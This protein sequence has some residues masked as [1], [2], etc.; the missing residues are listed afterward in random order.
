[1]F[2]DLR[3]SNSIVGQLP[4]Y[5]PSEYPNFVNFLKDYYRFLETNSNP[6]DLLNGIQ[7][8][9]DVD[10]YTGISTSANLKTPIPI[11]A[12]QIIVLG[13]VNFP[14][15]NGLLKINDEVILYKTR[16]HIQ[17]QYQS[18]K[19]TVFDG[20]VR[21]YD[22]NDLDI[23]T[24]FTANIKTEPSRH[25]ATSIVYNQSY[26]YIL[27][28]LEKL[29]S[30]YLIDFPKNVLEDNLD[31]LNIDTVLKKVKDF[32][33]SKGTPQ[34]I[35]F[36][37]KFL[38]Q[39]T[40][41]LRNYKENLIAPSEATYQS[42][43]VV[44]AESLDNFYSPDLV[45]DF[46]VQGGV[47]YPIQTVENV[48]SFASQV[49]EF[50]VSNGQGLKP[51][52]FTKITT[53]PVEKNGRLLV[54]V[55]STYGFP[56]SG[57]IRIGDAT[58]KYTNKESN[59][60][61]LD[62]SETTVTYDLGDSVY[63]FDTLATIKS[64]PSSY[65][66]IYAGV[67]GFK[68]DKNYTY[69][70]KGDTGFV[71]NF[72]VEDSKLVT[73]WSY[74]DILPVT[75]NN[76]LVSGIT[77]LYTDEES[78]Y[79]Y[80][81]SIPFYEFTYD[82]SK[83]ILEDPAFIR[84]IPKNFTKTAEGFKDSTPPAAPV[85]FLRDG[86]AI[87]NWKSR[88]TIVRGS[89]SSIEIEN[90]GQLFN[91]HNPP[92]IIIDA[93]TKLPGQTVN[94]IRAQANLIIHGRIEQVYIKNT[95]SGYVGTPIITVIKDPTDTVY[96]GDN[97]RQAILQPIVVK[98]KI[99]KVR[100]VDPGLGYT[101]QPSYEITATGYTTPASLELFVAGPIGQVQ[102]TNSGSL[103][104]QNPSYI[105]TK[106]TGATGVV[107]VNNGKITEVQVVNGGQEY[108]SRPE[109]TVIDGAGKG[110]G[111]V[112][113]ANYDEIA[114]QVTGFT[115]INSG[116][117]YSDIGTYIV[118]R[119][120]GFNEILNINVSSWNLINNYDK[121]NVNP[122]YDI[123][124][125]AYFAGELVV[126]TSATIV[127]KFEELQDF[128]YYTRSVPYSYINA[129]GNL[130]ESRRLLFYENPY[131]PG[132]T[133][134][135]EDPN[136]G[137]IL[138]GLLLNG[139]DLVDEATINQPLP[140]DIS[141]GSS[142]TSPTEAN[143][144]TFV[145]VTSN[146]VITFRQTAGSIEN[147]WATEQLTP[148][149]P[150]PSIQIGR[151]DLIVD[152]IYFANITR[153][154]E[155]Y[156]FV[157]R[158]EGYHFDTNFSKENPVV[159]E[160]LIYAKSPNVAGDNPIKINII[161][162]FATSLDDAGIFIT[163]ADDN[164]YEFA[165]VEAQSG[166]S[167]YY[168]TDNIP[169]SEPKK[170]KYFSILGA[171]KKLRVVDNRVSES[172]G[173]NDPTS[174]SPIIGWALDGAPIYGPYGYDNPLDPGSDI[175]KMKSGWKKFTQ[176]QFNNAG[177]SFRTQDS[178]T[179]AGLNNY[180]IGSFVEDYYW[181]EFNA[182]L[183]EQNGRYCVTPD[184]PNG[185]YA[186]FMTVDSN[187]KENGFPYY[188]GSNFAGK[189][190]SEFN[191]LQEVDIESITGIR[192][193]LNA[194][195]NATPKFIDPGRFV[196]DSVP[197]SIDA[198]L[199]YIDVVSPGTNYKIGDTLVFN[200]DDTEGTGAAGFVSVIKGQSVS[201]VSYAEYDYL[202][203][204]DENIPF[205]KGSTI[206]S[207]YGF[208]A[209]IH[210]IDQVNKWMYLSNVTG[211]L[212]TK[213][214]PIFDTTLTLEQDYKTETIGA[215]ISD[216]ILSANETTAELVTD[217]DSVTSYFELDTFI[218]CT[219]SNFNS[220][221]GI[222]V[223]I[224]INQEYMKVIATSSNYVLVERGFNSSQDSHSAG[225]T[226]TLLYTLEV[227]DSSPF[228]RGDIIRLTTSGVSSTTENFKII[229]IDVSKQYE[230]VATKILNGTGT[231]SGSVYYFYLDGQLQQNSLATSPPPLE[232]QVVVLDNNG[233]IE[234]IVIGNYP[235]AI[236]NPIA[237][238]TNQST[239]NPDTI[240]PNTEII[241]TTYKHTLIVERGLFGSTP[242]AHYPRQSVNRLRFVNGFVSYY[243]EDRILARLNA[244]NNLLVL[245]D[246][247]A[248]T[249]STKGTNSYTVGLSNNTLT[250]ITGSLILYEG[251]TYIFEVDL[252]SD[253]IAV[254]FYTPG[255]K[256]REYFDITIQRTFDITGNLEEFAL[257]PKSSDLTRLVM[258][259]TSLDDNTF[260]DVSI[261][262][263][264]EPINGEYKVVNSTNSY[265]EFYTKKDPILSLTQQYTRNNIRYTTTSSNS[266]G[267][268]E[269]ITLSS[270]GYY[271]QTV[272]R[273]DGVSSAEGTGAVLEAVSESIGRIKS[274]RSINTGYGYNP[275]PT[276][277]PSLLFP[278][279][280]KIS[281][282]FIVAST[283][284][285]DS[286]SDY[287]FT[288][289][290]VVSGGGLADG[291]SNHAS[292]Q[293]T[294]NNGRLIS[295]DILFAG[296]QYVSAPIID[297][298]KY[299][300]VTI[301][302]AG[303]LSF[304]FNFKQFILDDDPFKV[305]AYYR[306]NGIL[307]YV[308]SSIT[309]YASIQAASVSC[310]SSP[311]GNV[312]NPLNFITIPN[313][314]AP[315]YYELICVSR[316]AQATVLMQKSP[317]IEGEKVIFNNNPNYFGFIS[318]RKGWQANNS[319]L[320]IENYNYN[321]KVDDTI[322]GV[323]SSAYGV[324]SDT[325][326][327]LTSAELSSL[328]ETPKQF[329]TSKSFLGFNSLK[330]Q[331]SFRYQKFAYEIGTDIPS[332]Q[333]RENYLNTA[334][335]AG[336]N[337]FART[338]ISSKSKVE[339]KASSVVK[340][341][342]DINN[343]VRL[344]QKYNYLVT[345]NNGFDEVLVLN[346]LLTDVKSIN[347]SVVAAFEDISD[348]F[349]GIETSFELKVVDPVTPTDINGN[350]N[351]IQDYEI[352]QM[353]VLLD[354]IIQTYGTSWTVTDSDKVF[355]FTSTQNA[356]QLM[357]QGEV[358]TYRQFN[359]DTVIYGYNVITS[360]DT[361]TFALLQ[362]DNSVFPA[363]IFSSIDQDNYMVFVDGA[364]QLN[365][366]FTISGS[367]N[368]EIIFSEVIP[369][370]SQVSV[371]Y[372]NNFIKNEFTNS[373]YTTGSPLVLSSKP[374]TTSKESYFVFIDGIL[375]S[376]DD[377]NLDG[378]N[379]IEF[380]Y[381]F[382]YDSLIVIID[383]LGV[384]LESSTHNII[385]QL[386][387]YKIEDGQ[388]EIPAGYTIGEND[389]I[390][391]IAGVVQTPI[392]AY[393]ALTSG[394]RKINFS[395]PPQR[396]IGPDITVGRQFI[397]LLYQRQDPT[398][399]LGTTPNYQFD[400]I[401]K[402][403]IH[404]KESTTGFIIGDYINTATSSARIVDIVNNVN[405]KV[406][407]TGFTGSVTTNSNFDI[408]ISDINRIATG[409]RVLFNVS[410]GMTSATNNELEVVN[411]NTVTNTITL[412]NISA[413]T[414][415][416]TIANDTA[417]RFI[418]NELIVQNL[419]STAVDRDDAFLSSDVIESGIISSVETGTTTLLNEPYGVLEGDTEITVDNGA[420]FN[421][422][423]YL[424]INNNEIVKIT[425]IATNVLTVDRAQLKT[426]PYTHPDNAVVEQIVP[427]TLTVANFSRGFD[428][429][430][431]EF[432]LTENGTPIYIQ[433][434]KDIFVIING[435]LQK[436]GASY[437]LVEIDPDSNPNSGD[438][439]SKLVFSEPPSDG[440]PFNCFY[441][442]E[443]ISIQSIG[444]LFNGVETAFEL[445]STTGEIFSL[446]SN[447]R[448]E[449]NISANLILFIDG[450]YQIPSTTEEG[451]VEAYPDTL[452]SFK[453]L[454]SLIEFTSPP[455]FGSDFEGYIYVGSINDYES[456]DVDATVE[457]GD[458]IVQSNEIAPRNINNIISSTVLSV[459][460]SKGEIITA[461][462]SGINAGVNGTGWWLA[463][464]IKKERVRESLRVRRTLV[465]EID[466]LTN[467]PYPLSGKT[468]L[469][470]SI[471]SIDITNISSDLPTNP[472]DDTNMITFTLPATAN[473]GIRNINAKYTSFVPRN[474]LVAGDKDE[475]QGLF[476]GYDLPFNQIIKLH[477]SS[478]SETFINELLTGFTYGSPSKQAFVV[479]WDP[480]KQLLYIKLDDP[481]T[482]ITTSDIVLGYAVN[483]DDLIN[484]YQTL[485]VG[486]GIIYNF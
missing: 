143:A 160:V 312:V 392:V 313:N 262:T 119:E 340:L 329:L 307:K 24:G 467:T 458:I 423:D 275:D 402:N 75:V 483:A 87:Y 236:T 448:A 477:P 266:K 225:D 195:G 465:S 5:L 4:S 121:D 154:G 61:I 349:D 234:D 67:S 309:L 89:I 393:T 381:N 91:V 175:I 201:T 72:V 406:V 210:A 355:K 3:V 347:S 63:D 375:I 38:F 382:S 144:G 235:S 335:P 122:Y 129:S 419:E 486:N 277:K 459:S 386:Y 6:L 330:L 288:P 350:V 366:S 427:L 341:S 478:S 354:N 433:A 98:G 191:E 471:Q 457:A 139:V 140:F 224:K 318:T 141:F 86:T 365:S 54:Y 436:R 303:D 358:I 456:I 183:D 76:D 359:E 453:L 12:T 322:L 450:V 252:S 363:G 217:I 207:P 222:P 338:E 142:S 166:K 293:A 408:I 240:I 152:Q 11:D 442:G 107:T 437:N 27:Y 221:N 378:N 413:S 291:D 20:C 194:D 462:P 199:D 364:V 114:K 190:Y 466:T 156:A 339:N 432:I 203:Y 325:F 2:N 324:V 228:I 169:A 213:G 200:N 237:V 153:S 93:P 37:F 410:F 461:V 109:V 162:N 71:S 167:Y 170:Q 205:T 342:T 373:S 46:F 351:Y 328:V 233:D 344:N 99:T 346:R 396:Y 32:Y 243:E 285:T 460:D 182:D 360:S 395:E 414:L 96:T 51:T 179:N 18:Y 447:S 238:V 371:R 306:E 343:I 127:P 287:I 332:R 97:F 412:R 103:Y 212:P 422:G 161:E 193:F 327:V 196:V 334:H 362:E 48:F 367:N 66:V 337:L 425:N 100:I 482:P 245:N 136:N 113:I 50:E 299:Y 68:I 377:Y 333:W 10:T 297:I 116:I 272:P 435:I 411:I 126:Q 198:K 280:S 481:G 401:S 269:S 336:Y 407:T 480:V 417:I 215:Q 387:T 168:Y 84:R 250:G 418:H 469:T 13:H 424:V 164:N 106:G 218:N 420:L 256:Q 184:Y 429:D 214:E 379:D 21:G 135:N 310:L 370:G 60:F 163:Y 223:Y 39:S 74:N 49:Y 261:T 399:A 444:N 331:D 94:G 440:T 131:T 187:N 289:R 385:G 311:G 57:Y 384:S 41:E 258:R 73:N 19:L 206:E 181:T 443:L 40:P 62:Y 23:E 389:Y 185:V 33:L 369:S 244:Q 83:V 263:I 90:G 352:D 157:I 226:V 473:F 449:S 150:G 9:I 308:D 112:V 274:I 468:L 92:N 26:S 282:N 455:K 400:D 155:N 294:I 31:N 323:D 123:S 25:S 439:Y 292:F 259:I 88:N 192:R 316:K 296:L 270:G 118:V 315:E 77:T 242:I 283:V 251:S 231:S 254:G 463:D 216:V 186:Y 229:D 271:Y 64:T 281:K 345:K 445:R 124:T 368:G 209:T 56:S 138:D 128:E 208:S 409:D 326:G 7:S 302:S 145:S 319:I 485:N 29:R 125:G 397:G 273:V 44:R 434:D 159:F 171:P 446:I 227:F 180:T 357:P 177:K 34:G 476:V 454:G 239:Y 53:T 268:I 30:N 158:F 474:P 65:F 16:S 148:L 394:V 110:Q 247:V 28:F 398:G 264:P 202:E 298:E 278:K 189:T 305:R 70:Q 95:G 15:T 219:I 276:Q 353:V 314:A 428:G 45:G 388:I 452:A 115:V 173:L 426:V 52:K 260:Q 134:I 59:Y 415:S 320:R 79:L 348:Q 204:F 151:D 81:S 1:M 111:A 265:F 69:Y 470:T 380:N 431:T 130:V 220:V 475:L 230:V 484:E 17:D 356:G 101:K 464:I 441:V 78:I 108:N 8:L 146:G 361:N 132:D 248:I 172:I 383:P 165:R 301:S 249:A 405:R 472:D 35:D 372:L 85:G 376:T 416:I 105:I 43:Q 295:I 42:K 174:H 147:T 133:A 80:T 267:P 430:K 257:S 304:K 374:T 241:T 438:E 279:I 82:S 117:N 246:N 403:I 404:V 22:Y 284:I 36:Y 232:Q 176:T 102:I 58:Y 137:L 178:V 421:Q 211:T 197:T 120:T 390:L 149:Y 300:Y 290:V 451:R 104:N 317:F 188:I 391:D 321:F 253:N 255:A 55:D 14:K 286:G 47:D 479:N